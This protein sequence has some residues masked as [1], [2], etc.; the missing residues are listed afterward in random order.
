MKKY[1]GT[2]I[3][4][5]IVI[6]GVVLGFVLGGPQLT[7]LQKDTFIILAIMCG[8]SALYCFVV[9]E[10]SRNNSQMDKL[11]SILPIA[12]TW[13]IAAKSGMEPRV[14]IYSVLVTI[15]GVRLTINFARKGAYQLKFWAGEEDYRWQVLRQN[16]YLKNKFAWA[17]FDLFFIS[18]YQNTLVLAICL[19]ALV[20]M[21][22]AEPLGL[23]DYA[24]TALTF[25]F[26]LLETAADEQQMFFHTQKRQM[27]AEGKSLEELPEPFNKGF[28][29]YGLWAHAR[30]PNYFAEQAIWICL[31]LFAIG[32]G[33]TNYVVFNWTMVGPLV[34]VFLFLG[35][36]AFGESVSSS[37]YPEYKYYQAN[38]SKY[39]PLWRYNP[40]KAEQKVRNAEA[41]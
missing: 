27:L 16:K 6:T 2:V 1:L 33:A 32:A 21:G 34:L 39:V 11:W 10:L 8:S 17:M 26:I 18:I 7:D 12:Y 14:V 3:T 24:A 38:V 28:N 30:H 5:I 13:V 41:K 22:S 20:C 19:P 29:T 31:Y 4:V 25:G 9:G 15:W 23:W 40:E 36:S 35:S 37:K